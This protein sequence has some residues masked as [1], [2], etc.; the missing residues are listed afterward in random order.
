MTKKTIETVPATNYYKIGEMLTVHTKVLKKK[1]YASGYL[2]VENSQPDL[3]TLFNIFTNELEFVKCSTKDDLIT[4]TFIDESIKN[5]DNLK[6]YDIVVFKDT[7]SRK[8]MKIFFVN[9]IHKDNTCD[10]TKV[11]CLGLTDESLVLTLKNV[12]MNLLMHVEHAFR[13]THKTKYNNKSYTFQ[14]YKFYLTNNPEENI[15]VARLIR[16]GQSEN[17]DKNDTT[18]FCS[19]TN[20]DINKERTLLN[21]CF[22]Y[23]N[24]PTI[25][26]KV[27]TEQ[28][29]LYINTFNE[30][31]KQ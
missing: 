4:S 8:R 6:K 25:I 29:K 24:D 12:N 18:V 10:L 22:A 23:V 1:K 28:I 19:G 17:G 2:V 30:V 13:I 15:I 21:R 9:K 5:N 20:S 31:S 16:E 14:D 11:N 27:S 3:L 26:M 7:I